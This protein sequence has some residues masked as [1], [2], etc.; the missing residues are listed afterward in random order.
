M[1]GVARPR[2]AVV[3]E[4]LLDFAGSERVLRDILET[5]PQADL[6]ALVD[7]PDEELRT[8]IP[9]RAKAT[10]FLQR[11]PR[12]R[13]WLRYYVPLMPLAVGQLDVSA[14][15]IVVSSSHSCTTAMRGPAAPLTAAPGSSSDRWRGNWR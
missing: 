1:S 3:H 12:P 15:D 7:Q 10:S 2:I 8:A 13:R 9:R 6:F 14:Y 11:L 4:W 5:V